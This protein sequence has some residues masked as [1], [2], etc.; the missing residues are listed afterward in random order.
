[1]EQT[2]RMIASKHVGMK[3]VGEMTEQEKLYLNS[4][5]FFVSQQI[6]LSEAD[7]FGMTM[8]QRQE[9]MNAIYI[10]Y[11]NGVKA[12]IKE[13]D[14]ETAVLIKNVVSK[15]LDENYEDQ[16]IAAF[17]AHPDDA[18]KAAQAVTVNKFLVVLVERK[19][20][21]L[22]DAVMKLAVTKHGYLVALDLDSASTPVV[23]R[24]EAKNAPA[25]TN[26]PI[27]AALQCKGAMKS[28]EMLTSLLNTDMFKVKYYINFAMWDTRGENFL[29]WALERV[30]HPAVQIILDYVK[31]EFDHIQKNGSKLEKQRWVDF[32][33]FDRHNMSSQNCTVF[34][35]LNQNLKQCKK[36]SML[37]SWIFHFMD[38]V[39]QAIEH[40][41]SDVDHAE[42]EK[43]KEASRNARLS[44]QKPE[45]KEE[46]K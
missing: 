24:M 36:N 28:A 16:A 22:L 7:L 9:A 20:A 23:A 27:I 17:Q 33:L 2:F 41:G 1:M 37:K 30:R 38:L 15:N 46:E 21:R 18:F 4:M 8:A 29:D 3:D 34:K 11:K 43:Y 39:V 44:K 45:E 10:N 31:A 5:E 6:D 40:L 14:S 32:D 13:N 12:N 26:N 42:L 35:K 25:S 19:F